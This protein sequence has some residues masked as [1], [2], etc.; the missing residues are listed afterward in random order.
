MP[1]QK[2]RWKNEILLVLVMLSAI[3]A[4]SKLAVGFDIDEGYAVS[5]PYRLLQGDHFFKDMWEVHQTSS[6]LPALF[7]VLYQKVTGGME[8]CVLYL[9]IVAAVIH[10]G[11]TLL[12]C[13]FLTKRT[14]AAWSC[15]LTLLYYNLLPKWMLTLDFSMQQVWGMT[16]LLLLLALETENGKNRYAFLMGIVLACTVLAYPGMVL[17]YPALCISIVML[18]KDAPLK[19]KIRKCL[20]LTAGCLLMAVLFFA[21]VLSFMSLRE[22]LESIPMVFMDGTHQFTFQTKLMTYLSQWMNV[23]KQIIILSVPAL[24]LSGVAV[25]CRRHLN[26]GKKPACVAEAVLQQRFIYLYLILFVTVASLLVIFANLFG[27]QIGPFHFQVRYLLFFAA[28]FLLGMTRGQRNKSRQEQYLFWGPLFLTMISFFAILLFSNVGPDSSSSYLGTGLIAGFLL[29]ETQMRQDAG[30]RGQQQELEQEQKKQ[31]QKQTDNQIS[32]NLLWLVCA[33]FVLSL[34]F[35][36]GY[37]VR[38]TE[39]GPSTVLQEREKIQTGPLKGIY[40]LPED[41]ERMTSDQEVIDKAT[42]GEESMLYLGTEGISNLYAACPF[43]SPSTISTPAFNEQWVK[44]FAR[45]PEKE[46]SVIVIAKNTIDDRDKFFAQ[47]PFGIWISE[48][49]DILAME[50]TAS[51]CIIRK[52]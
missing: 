23:G 40:V 47:N 19:E 44:Y 12:V 10:L 33:L 52:K 36:K 28:V 46:P 37:Y 32:G 17:C 48:K 30:L 27:I 34:I 42:E 43:V 25:W 50:E 11:I 14:D 16:L 41:Y 51:L 3:A 45:Y 29:L 35:C 13:R 4:Y 26:K 6:F 5:M 9:R 8:G 22:L 7:L 1:V 20:I 15:I 38:I 39:Y 18:H 2:N 24:L 21:Y 49:Y 31:Q